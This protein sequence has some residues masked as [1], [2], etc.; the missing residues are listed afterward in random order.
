MSKKS[1][2]WLLGG[3]LGLVGLLV[4]LSKTGVMGSDS[5]TK[6]A[7][8]EAGLHDIIESVSAS[9]K[10]YPV[11]E[12]KVSP[13][14]SGEVTD[15][16]V[17]EGD[18]VRKGQVL[19][20]INSTIYK[21]AV[22]R[23]NAQLNQT[24]SSVSNA[25]AMLLQAKAQ[26]DQA[27]STYER[28]RQLFED[29]VISAVEFESAQAA[30]KTA[31]ANYRGSTETIKGNQY[32][33]ASAQAN[34]SEAMQSLRKTTIYAPMSGIVSALFVKK[35]ERVVGTA[36]M[37]GTEIM[38][39]ANMSRMK[40]DVE[41]GENDI[42]KVKYND[43]A[44]IEVEAYPSRKFKGVVVK[45]SQSSTTAG[46]QAAAA[47]SDQVSNYTVGIELL[48]ESYQ[49]L[50]QIDSRHFPFRP[51]MSA[52]VDILTKFERQTL[53]VPINA[54]T[55]RE[56]DEIENG[57]EDKKTKKEDAIKEYVFIV[58]KDNK[59]E[60]REVKTAMQDNEYI[61]IT[62]GLKQGEHVVIAP[63]SAIARTLKKDTKVKVVPKKELF[64]IKKG[65]DSKD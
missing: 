50:L 8:E 44:N 32:G 39:I 26:L 17:E 46:S 5:T 11:S 2:Y 62:S 1:I 48:P 54:V 14:V 27:T 22:N 24:R 29:K 13:D 63:F 16:F 19:A 34:V 58:S 45:I 43:T 65:E 10:I 12:V 33:V 49:D 47:M 30:Y 61:K 55:T 59:T 38:R 42:Q 51:G 21:A 37:A 60:L 36:Q 57:K 56:E 7:I 31:Q 9:G 4:I 23:A 18:S 35:G 53:A 41:V 28:N 52:S 64:D 6:V 40:V 25:S 3:V 15:L 20:T